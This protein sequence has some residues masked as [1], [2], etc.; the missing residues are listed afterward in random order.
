M[1]AR[2]EEGDGVDGRTSVVQERDVERDAPQELLWYCEEWGRG[3]LHGRRRKGREGSGKVSREHRVLRVPV[4]E[5][6]RGRQL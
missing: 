6:D 1:F 3:G 5:S 4:P 2:A